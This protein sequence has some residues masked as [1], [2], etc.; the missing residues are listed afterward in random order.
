MNGVTTLPLKHQIKKRG[1]SRAVVWEFRCSDPLARDRRDGLARG[2]RLAL[3]ADAEEFDDVADLRVA[4]F[5]EETLD[6]VRYHHER[7][8][9]G[10]YPMG[11]VGDEIPLIARLMAVADAYSAMTSDRPYRKGMAHSTALSILRQGSGTQW[12]TDSVDALIE[13]FEAEELSRR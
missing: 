10:G 13:G 5:L 8:D 3:G 11:L 6:A 4:A 7:W 12:D 2:G 9:G 1:R